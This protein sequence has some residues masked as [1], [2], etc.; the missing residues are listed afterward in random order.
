MIP[1]V[2]RRVIDTPDVLDAVPAFR[3][4]RAPVLTRADVQREWRALAEV[5]SEAPPAP[6]A[7]EFAPPGAWP[8]SWGLV[9][10]GGF[11]FGYLVA[12]CV[13]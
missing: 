7:K 13:A 2:E 6:A 9:G 8:W 4:R 10:L 12:W 1:P 3:S 11:A 5:S